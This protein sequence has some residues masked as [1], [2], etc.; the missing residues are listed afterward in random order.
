VSTLADALKSR[1]DKL[2]KERGEEQS[3]K[4][5]GEYNSVILHML[6]EAK[7]KP[8]APLRAVEAKPITEDMLSVQYK[9][10]MKSLLADEIYSTPEKIGVDKF[11]AKM[12]RESDAKGTGE[13]DDDDVVVAAGVIY[14]RLNI[15]QDMRYLGSGWWWW[16][17]SI[18]GPKAELATIKCV[19]YQLH[20]TFP[21]KTLTVKDRN[22]RFAME[23]V[24]WGEFE[25]IAKVYRK[26]GDPIELKHWLMLVD[27]KGNR[28]EK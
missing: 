12:V 2:A 4:M 19:V 3:F 6:Q 24:G 7:D 14:S 10:V 17:V 15:V 18:N 27:D 28:C 20:E 22:T 13:E 16:S 9:P 25:V 11:V 21:N 26:Q 5:A 23:Q 1:I 8:A